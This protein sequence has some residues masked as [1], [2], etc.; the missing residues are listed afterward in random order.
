[1][2]KNK[3]FATDIFKLVARIKSE[4]AIFLEGS[5][6]KQVPKLGFK[7]F[8]FY[9]TNDGILYILDFIVR[10]KKFQPLTFRKKNMKHINSWKTIRSFKKNL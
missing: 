3:T 7:S 4:N 9:L 8:N 6:F 5:I 1:M 2:F 10:F